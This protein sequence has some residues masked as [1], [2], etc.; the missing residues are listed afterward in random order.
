MVVIHLQDGGRPDVYDIN[1]RSYQERGTDK[2]KNCKGNCRKCSGKCSNETLHRY[3]YT[4][5]LP[6]RSTN[7][8]TIKSYD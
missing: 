8:R 4:F 3:W 2:T 5:L 7:G 1:I 6:V